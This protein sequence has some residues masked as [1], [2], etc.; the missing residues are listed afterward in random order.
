M[1][2]S[3]VF[4]FEVPKTLHYFITKTTPKTASVGATSDRVCEVTGKGRTIVAGRTGTISRLHL[5]IR[6]GVEDGCI[7]YGV[8]DGTTRVR[9]LM[10]L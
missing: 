3:P 5:C 2:S 6:Y 7:R 10:M 1:V 9:Y 4:E 8:E